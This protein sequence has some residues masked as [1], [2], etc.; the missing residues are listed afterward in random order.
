MRVIFQ[1]GPEFLFDGYLIGS[2][3][4]IIIFMIMWYLLFDAYL[5]ER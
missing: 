4:R 1:Y 3:N 2:L 5:T